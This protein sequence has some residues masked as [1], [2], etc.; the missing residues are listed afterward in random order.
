MTAGDKAHRDTFID[1]VVQ[2][3]IAAGL[4]SSHHDV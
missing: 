3:L 2:V 1:L 4:A